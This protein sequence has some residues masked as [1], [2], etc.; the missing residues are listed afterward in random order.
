L[1]HGVRFS[2]LRT[3]I[4]L[5]TIKTP[6]G[7]KVCCSIPS[8]C[9]IYLSTLRP[10]LCCPFELV[11]I[12]LPI[13][14]TCSL[15][16]FDSSSILLHI[17][18][19]VLNSLLTCVF[20]IIW[21]RVSIFIHVLLQYIYLFWIFLLFLSFPCLAILRLW[22]W[23]LLCL[24]LLH[25]S[26]VFFLQAL[27]LCF[28]FASFS[29]F[30]L[31]CKLILV[32]SLLQAYSCFIFVASVSPFLAISVCSLRLSLLGTP[33]THNGGVSTHVAGVINPFDMLL[34]GD[35]PFL[36]IMVRAAGSLCSL[37]VVTS[38][39]KCLHHYMPQLSNTISP[40]CILFLSPLLGLWRL[41][42]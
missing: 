6:C 28:V 36:D 15:P 13:L 4:R 24:A 27:L 12:G 30:H 38:P 39:C 8:Y 11:S 7:G 23:L 14:M 21:L 26:F 9:I 18:G 41:M 5:S 32:L 16:I 22:F 25:W 19:C 17:G 42:S 10:H 29:L 37:D 40:T 34:Q 31:C 20:I 1:G 2:V 35:Q 3:K 33:N